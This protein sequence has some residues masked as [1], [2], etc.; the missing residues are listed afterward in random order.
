MHRS[1][2]FSKQRIDELL[3]KPFA[4]RAIYFREYRGRPPKHTWNRKAIVGP[5]LRPFAELQMV[6]R[7]EKAGWTAGWCYRARKFI[8]TWEPEKRVV[9]F[10]QQAE[11]LLE[12]IATEAGSSAGCWDVFAWKDGKPLF[13][14]LKRSGSGDELRDSQKRWRK[15]AEALKVSPDAFKEYEWLGG[16]LT[17]YS[18]KAMSCFGVDVQS[19]VRYQHGLYEFGGPDPAEAKNWLKGYQRIT[20]LKGADAL[21]VLFHDNTAGVTY[22]DIKQTKVRIRSR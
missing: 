17:G 22:W 14:E 10:P 19:W 12:R 11:D 18:L 13:I 6:E 15:A 3:G 20:G 2:Q 4:D 8:S 21:W 1:E 16:D 9:T 7:L 5:P